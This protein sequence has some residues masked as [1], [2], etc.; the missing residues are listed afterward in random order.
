MSQHTLHGFGQPEEPDAIGGAFESRFVPIGARVGG[1]GQ[2]Y[3]TDGAGGAGGLVVKL[4][5]WGAG[6]PEQAVQNFTRDA[7]R[8]ASLRH[9]HVAHVVDA[10]VLG[11]GTPFLVME[12]LAGVTLE[13][14][15]DGRQRA[16]ADVLP[17]LRGVGSALAAAHAAG[18][19][20]GQVR[21]DNVFIV[22]PTG[23]WPS[24]P[25]LLDFGV[26]RLRVAKRSQPELGARAG[27][28]A[29]QLA[30]A[31]LAWQLLGGAASPALQRLLL[32]AMNPDPRQRFGTIAAL[33]DALEEASAGAAAQPLV[34]RG[35]PAPVPA[36]PPSSLTQQFF[37]EGELLEKAHAMGQAKDTGTDA[38][39]DDADDDSDLVPAAPTRLPR[40]RT[41]MIMAA[42]LALGSAALVA[43]T[44]VSLASKPAAVPAAAIPPAI[45]IPRPVVVAPAS[46]QAPVRATDR[47]QRGRPAAPRRASTVQP[48][49]F[50]APPRPSSVA[51][52]NVPAPPRQIAPPIPAPLPPPGFPGGEGG[53]APVAAVPPPSEA[54]G[55]PPAEAPPAEATRAAAERT[56]PP[57]EAAPPTE[58]RAAPPAEAAPP[59]PSDDESEPAKS[60]GAESPGAAP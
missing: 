52:S 56:V 45:A 17:I 44:V 43:W 26:A 34:R 3:E 50:A 19:V 40:S 27:E 15:M 57:A 14:A 1:S 59:A 60:P 24:C 13:E 30:L 16:I 25:K 6:L 58:D 8:V 42:V 38:P 33:L 10:G 46:A 41:Q 51:A 32:R 4:F 7:M 55:P 48:P 11:D 18:V 12:R 23:G 36:P 28:R 39:D 5:T 49:P 35:L 21:A 31:T 37:A 29:D 47:G 9:P 22:D 20:H 2:V 54:A 53:P